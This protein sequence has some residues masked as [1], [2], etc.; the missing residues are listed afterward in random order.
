MCDSDQILLDRS[1]ELETKFSD[2]DAPLIECALAAARS[3]YETAPSTNNG[4]ALVAVLEFAEHVCEEI[5]AAAKPFA[6]DGDVHFRFAS[7]APGKPIARLVDSIHR[8]EREAASQRREFITRAV[9]VK[10]FAEMA[11]DAST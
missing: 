2:L 11:A 10:E 8:A 9:L 1:R 5:T 3:L 6:T 7:W 4:L